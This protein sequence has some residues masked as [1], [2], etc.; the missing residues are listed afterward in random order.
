MGPPDGMAGARRRGV[1]PRWP[2]VLPV[3]TLLASTNAWALEPGKHRQL[4][5]RACAGVGLPDAFCRRMGKQAY[6]TDYE[7]W[8]DLSAHAQRELG[9]DRC[10]AA[11]AA[12]S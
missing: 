3:L 12:V 7:E 1:V 4:A 9:Q 6:E 2:L 11:D 10:T 8:H 5:E